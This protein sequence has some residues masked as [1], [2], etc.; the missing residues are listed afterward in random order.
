MLL[1]P[2]RI[3]DHGIL[4]FDDLIVG[5]PGIAKDGIIGQIGLVEQMRRISQTLSDCIE[6]RSGRRI[7]TNRFLN[8]VLAVLIGGKDQLDRIGF[9]RI[10]E[11]CWIREGGTAVIP[12]IPLK[13]SNAT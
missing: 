8:G 5:E 1:T 11:G 9:G 3:L 4:S 6:V 13:G 12:K 2:C 7:D 10:I